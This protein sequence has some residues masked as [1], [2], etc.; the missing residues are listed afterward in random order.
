MVHLRIVA[1][2]E[3]ARRALE[4]LEASTSVSNVVLLEGA[5]RKPRG[6]VIECVVAREDA[7]VIIDDLRELEIP[8]AGSIS[9]EPVGTLLS[10]AAEEAEERTP[11]RESD[12]VVWEEVEHRSHEMTE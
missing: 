6:D 9:V 3:S 12:S 10:E 2:Q 11:G 8:A 7:S 5:A 4:L 1:P